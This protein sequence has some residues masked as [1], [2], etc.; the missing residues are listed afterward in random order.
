VETVLTLPS[1]HD[2]DDPVL[3]RATG[4][5]VRKYLIPRWMRRKFRGRPLV[6]K[7]LGQREV[8][9]EIILRYHLYT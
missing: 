6:L 2:P 7:D 8:N 3:V 4:I 9:Y 1:P 5:F